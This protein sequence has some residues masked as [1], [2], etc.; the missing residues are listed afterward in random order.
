VRDPIAPLKLLLVEGK[1]CLSLS[2]SLSLSHRG[3]PAAG[4][5]L[6]Q[7]EDGSLDDIVDRHPPHA[8]IIGELHLHPA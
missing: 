8:P 2:L 7:E 1:R 6:I 5:P 4:A 3:Q